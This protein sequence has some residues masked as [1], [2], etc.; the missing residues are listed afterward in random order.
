MDDDWDGLAVSEAV[1][2]LGPLPP[3][4]VR[5]IQRGPDAMIG[6]CLVAI[7]RAEEAGCAD[8]ETIPQLERLAL[9][10][11]GPWARHPG[12]VP[13]LAFAARAWAVLARNHPEPSHV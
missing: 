5:A 1:R 6:F 13:E 9:A 2:K 12:R 11:T 4:L 3:E 8:G 7:H 10:L